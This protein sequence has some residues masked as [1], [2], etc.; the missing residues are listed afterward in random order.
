MFHEPQHH[1]R[2]TA[3]S[4]VVPHQQSAQRRQHLVQGDGL[5][6]SLL[7]PLS[8]GGLH[9]RITGGWRG[10]SAQDARTLFLQLGMQDRICIPTP[11]PAPV[12]GVGEGQSAL[13]RSH[14]VSAIDLQTRRLESGP[15]AFGN[16]GYDRHGCA[17]HLVAQ[18]ETT[19][20]GPLIGQVVN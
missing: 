4:Q 1:R 10:Q 13:A 6:Q 7:P 20:K 18:P 9:R 16:T 14:E 19:G 5:T 2:H 3:A 15:Q 17:S 11:N 12:G 8:Q